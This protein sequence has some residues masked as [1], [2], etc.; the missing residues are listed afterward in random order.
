MDEFVERLVND[1]Q[2]LKYEMN[3]NLAEKK[4]L[5]ELAKLNY[6]ELSYN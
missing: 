4:I 1:H 6:F 3:L 5:A 2:S